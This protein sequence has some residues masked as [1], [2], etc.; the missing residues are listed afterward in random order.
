MARKIVPEGQ[1]EVVAF[2]QKPIRRVLHDDEWYFSVVDVIEVLTE[3]PRPRKYWADLKKKL[4]DEGCDQLS[5]NIGQLKMPGSD[6]KYYSTDA[7][8]TEVLFRIVQ[9][10]PS[11]KAETIKRWLAKMG[12]ERILERQ[13]PDIAIKRAILDYKMQGRSDEWIEARISCTLARQGL[14]GEWAKRGIEGP[15]YAIL[16]NLIHERAFD[17]SV[18][19][20]GGFKGLTKKHNLRDHMTSTEL[21]FTPVGARC[22]PKTSP[23]PKMLEGFEKMKVLP[24][25]AGR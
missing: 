3:S 5:D 18:H 10:I 25:K 15:Q 2:R 9:S 16:T 23:L 6:G 1:F 4:L 17:V 19:Q 24:V 22:L 11:K 12:Y 8:N 21:L 7:A 14:T 13:N 20:H